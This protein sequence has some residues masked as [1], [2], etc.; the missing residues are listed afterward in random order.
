MNKK[1]RERLQAAVAHLEMATGIVEDVRNDEQ[2]SLDN[3]PENLRQSE[4]YSLM[5]DAIDYL[6]DA[7]SY[8]NDANDLIK[9]ACDN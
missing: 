5:E 6:E 7:V 4:R 3:M 2:D 9:Q 1:R 8:L